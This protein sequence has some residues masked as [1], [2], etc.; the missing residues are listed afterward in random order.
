MQLCTMNLDICGKGL[1]LVKYRILRCDQIN[2]SYRT[3]CRNSKQQQHDPPQSCYHNP[4]DTFTTPSGL[5][6]FTGRHICVFYNYFIFWMFPTI[7]NR[8]HTTYSKFLFIFYFTK[9]NLCFCVK[10]HI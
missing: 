8:F 1:K 7:F 2:K 4:L 5:P 6:F 9:Y 3:I 10:P